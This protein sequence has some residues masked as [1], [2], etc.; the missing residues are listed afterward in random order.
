MKNGGDTCECIVKAD[1]V[2]FAARLRRRIN[3]REAGE[4]II[5][6][7]KSVSFYSREGNMPEPH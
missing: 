4:N 1:N 7:F 3:P 2:G 6:V 5:F